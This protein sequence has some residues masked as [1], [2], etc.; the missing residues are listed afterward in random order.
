MNRVCHIW[1]SHIHL[2]LRHACH[3]AQHFFSGCIMSSR[4]APLT[5]KSSSSLKSRKKK[6]PGIIEVEMKE[7]RNKRGSQVYVKKKATKKMASTT[8][9]TTSTPGPTPGPSG[10][11][12]RMRD[13][14]VGADDGHGDN[15]DPPVHRVKK[16]KR[17]TKVSHSE[18]FGLTMVHNCHDFR[19]KMITYANFYPRG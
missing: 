14:S 6:L 4:K 10:P 16:P 2:T 11:F 5:R 18:S 15:D 1:F 19:L 8:P 7:V 9:D 13:D 17:S 12:K 3:E